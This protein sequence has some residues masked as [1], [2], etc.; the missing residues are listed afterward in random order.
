MGNDEL[1]R[2]TPRTCGYSNSKA[3]EEWAGHLLNPFLINARATVGKDNRE[4]IDY[5]PRA[6]V[7]KDNREGSLDQTSHNIYM[8]MGITKDV[9]QREQENEHTDVIRNERNTRNTR[10][11]T[12]NSTVSSSIDCT[13][14]TYGTD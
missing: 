3:V 6:T 9:I 2:P 11:E 10:K 8:N 13:L 14:C 7:G 4:Y 5:I 1:F 12:Q